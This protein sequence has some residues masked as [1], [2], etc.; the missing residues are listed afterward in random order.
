MKKE[1]EI[2]SLDGMTTD[3]ISVEQDEAD[4][5]NALNKIGIRVAAFAG[6]ELKRNKGTC[7]VFLHLSDV[8]LRI[9][10]GN[11]MLA[12]EFVPSSNPMK[13]YHSGFGVQWFPIEENSE[14]GKDKRESRKIIG[15]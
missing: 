12:I 2:I 10:S 6:S 9:D 13:K 1:V 4:L 3:V 7:E 8:G 14:L 11:N 5:I 15:E